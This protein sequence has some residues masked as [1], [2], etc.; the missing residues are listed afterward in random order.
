MNDTG[1]PADDLQPLVEG[2]RSLLAA[3]GALPA[4]RKLAERLKVNRYRLR[5][6]LEALRATGEIAPRS[7]RRGMSSARHGEAL[8][9]G[10][11]PTEVIE[12]RM[13]LE[14]A[15]ARLA[16]LRASPLDILR[17]QHAA[18]TAAGSDAGAVD[19]A[20][21]KAIA[22]GAR[23]H[24]AA[25]LY[26]LLRRVGTDARLRLGRD[27]PACPTRIQQR[28]AEH[29]AIAEA[30]AAR[31]PDGA[32]QAMRAHLAAVQRRILEQMAPGL[33][34]APAQPALSA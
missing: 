8:V 6:A 20:F 21:H 27:K 5:R 10:T 15:L 17:I 18:R 2:L 1:L 25:E 11:N 16:A 7:G 34:T 29:R 12:M 31:D 26:T 14:P 33:T 24:L 9:R 32:E 4:E 19:L 13:M 23:N 30:I 22:A 3:E 28:D